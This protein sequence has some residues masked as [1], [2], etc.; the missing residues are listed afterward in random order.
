MG[1]IG[2]VI[3]PSGQLALSLGESL[4]KG[5]TPAM[6]A[7][8]A[9]GKDGKPVQSNHP[10]WVYGHLAS[11][12]SRT[13]DMLGHPDAPKFKNPALEAACKNGTPCLDDPSGKTYPAMEAVTRAYLD[14][15]RLA[16][17][18]LAEADDATLLRPNPAEGRMKDLLP[19]TGAMVS[20]LVAAHPMNHLGQVSAWRRFM[21]LG[22]PS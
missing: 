21:G 19:T 16:L 20:F 5:V 22:S 4:L 10:A 2:K 6:F 7:R 13:L 14:G 3:A 1:H 18:A 8:L 12:C 9:V 15:Y 17:S 11:Y